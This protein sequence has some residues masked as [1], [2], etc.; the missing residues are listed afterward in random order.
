MRRRIVAPG[1][2][3]G[4]RQRLV[5][6]EGRREVERAQP[7]LVGRAKLVERVEQRIA[8]RLAESAVAG[9]MQQAMDAEDL[10]DV[11]LRAVAI[12]DLV[13]AV[14]DQRRADPARRAEAAALVG[15]EMGEVAGDLE[16]VAMCAENRERAGR[17]HILESDAASEFVHRQAA[18]RWTADLHRLRIAGTTVVEHL[19]DGDAKGVFIDPG[20]F[21]VAGDRQQLGAGRLLAAETGKPGATPERDQR[22]LAQGLDVVHHRRLPR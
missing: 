15:E 11:V 18:T 6:V 16:H 5:E 4:D 8:R 12:G 7:P 1:H 2:L 13:H 22:C 3:A 14:G 9:G 20:R 10:A 21:D 17:R 19:V